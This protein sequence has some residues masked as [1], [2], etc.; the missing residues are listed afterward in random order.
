MTASVSK[1]DRNT[2]TVKKRTLIRND[3][4]KHVELFGVSPLFKATKQQFKVS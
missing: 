1:H 4:T 3:D 2:Q